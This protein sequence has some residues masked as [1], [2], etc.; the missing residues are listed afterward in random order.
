MV[1]FIPSVF[2]AGESFNYTSVIAI[3]TRNQNISCI[4]HQA[5]WLVKKPSQQTLS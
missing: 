1:V 2:V 4:E 3:S 5:D